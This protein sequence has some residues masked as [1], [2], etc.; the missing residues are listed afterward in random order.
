MTVRVYGA[1]DDLIEVEGDLREEFG[2]CDTVVML[3]FADGTRLR[4]VYSPEGYNGR[5]QIAV[6]DDPTGTVKH[7]PALDE[8]ANYSDVV[9]FE[10]DSRWVECW[11]EAGPD[12]DLLAQTL[13]EWDWGREKPE[14]LLKMYRL[15]TGHV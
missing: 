8:D 13:E 2:A 15:L 6:L 1:S 4:V 10:T 11:G 5:W 9:E 7:T 12:P 3:V 14:K